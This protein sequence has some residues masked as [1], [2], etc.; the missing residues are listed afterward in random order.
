MRLPDTIEAIDA[1]WLSD[2]LGAPVESFSVAPL[3]GGVLALAYRIG[4]IRYARSGQSEPRPD[5]VVLKIATDV[6][7]QRAMAATSGLYAREFT[8]FR[9]LAD[10]VPLRSPRIHYADSDGSPNCE[11]FVLVMEDLGRHSRVFDQVHDNPD[12][13]FARRMALEVAEMHARF[14]RSPRLDELPIRGADRYTFPM[15]AACRDAP[16]R[17]DEFEATWRALFRRG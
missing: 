10:A 1:D 8:F 9:D 2:A 13:Y 17:I 12:E 3:E 7:D 15:E 11:R 16:T 6:A 5:S 4:G 14:W